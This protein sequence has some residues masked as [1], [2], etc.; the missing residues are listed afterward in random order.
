MK[1]QLL[2][3]LVFVFFCLFFQVKKT[4]ESLGIQLDNKCMFLPQA[5]T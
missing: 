2:F 1:L 5:S 4:V 3:F